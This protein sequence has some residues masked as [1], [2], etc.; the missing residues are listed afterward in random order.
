QWGT[1][2]LARKLGLHKSVVHRLLVTLANGGLLIQDPRTGAFALAPTMITL[3]RRAERGGGLRA[4]ARPILQR[5]VE[6]SRETV[7]LCVMQEDH[8]LCLEMVDSPQSMRFKLSPGDSFPLNAGCGGK[9]IL[10]FQAPAFV[11]ALIER[12]K[13]QRI[14]DNTITDPQQLLGALAR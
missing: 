14:T 6:E 12:G 7:G 8:G 1:S 4:I 13:L 10:A 5:L 3:G 2:A 9:V 11:E